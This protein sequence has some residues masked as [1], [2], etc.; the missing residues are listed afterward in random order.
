[1]K[2]CNQIKKINQNK[3]CEGCGAILTSDVNKIGYTPVI[4]KA[5]FCQRCFKLKYYNKES[6][7]NN[8]F[9][10]NHVKIVLNNFDFSNKAV[11]FVCS[12]NQIFFNV[13]KVKEIYKKSKYF[14]LIISKIDSLIN[15]KN[16]D[17]IKNKLYKFLQINNIDISLNQLIICSAHLNLNYSVIQ[18]TFLKL[19]SKNIKVVFCGPTNA[20]KSSLINWIIKREKIENINNLTTSY[21]RNTTQD[22][23]Q[24]KLFKKGNFIDLP[25]FVDDNS[26]QII[27]DNDQLKKFCNE[28]SKWKNKIFQL[29][30]NRFLKFENLFSLKIFINQNNKNSSNIITYFNDNLKIHV[31]N[32][33]NKNNEKINFDK[34]NLVEYTYDLNFNYNLL[35]LNN[36]GFIVLKNVSKIILYLDKKLSKPILFENEKL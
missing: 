36:L 7:V 32:L 21:Y 10:E 22:I 26:F 27:M 19:F 15:I 28:K 25:G 31:V 11:F 9:L 8:D 24:I 13:S 6:I 4:E 33:N 16:L 14:Y 29:R 17:K 1:M 12:P 18:S 20:G 3:K 30:N 35:V 2:S 23:K 34:Q 5:K